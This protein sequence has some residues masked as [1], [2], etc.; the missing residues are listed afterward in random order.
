[1]H[2]AR[3]RPDSADLASIDRRG[4]PRCAAVLTSWARVER[5]PTDSAF[6]TLDSLARY[7]SYS[8]FLGYE[9][10]VMA[11]LYESRGDTA[12][13][14]RSIRRYPREYPGVW[15]APTLREEGRLALAMGDSAGA[16]RAYERYLELRADAEPPYA[17]ERDSIRAIV[18][19]LGMPKAAPAR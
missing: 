15:L 2:L 18:T 3:G 16:R 9:N 10:R 8:T 19:R 14:L 5:D 1:M 4:T 6:G 17:A 13:A 7:F 11:R 12:G